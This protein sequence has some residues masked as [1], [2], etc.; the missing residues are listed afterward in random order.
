LL[1][2]QPVYGQSLFECR[3]TDR[4]NRGALVVIDQVG[5]VQDS[6]T[7]PLKQCYVELYPSFVVLV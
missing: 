1:K 3:D 7:L 2:R 6:V 5:T 4:F